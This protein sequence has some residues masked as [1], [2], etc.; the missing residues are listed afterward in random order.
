M[1]ADFDPLTNPGKT[2]LRFTNSFKSMGEFFS[3]ATEEL[4][5]GTTSPFPSAPTFAAYSEQYD[6]YYANWSGVI[7]E[8]SVYEG[9]EPLA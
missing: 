4:D 8:N 6:Y 3:R 7:L 2:M 5:V 1:P 9:F